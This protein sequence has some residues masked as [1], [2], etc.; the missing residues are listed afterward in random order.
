[1]QIRY[2]VSFPYT[3]NKLSRLIDD[4]ATGDTV[5]M[6]TPNGDKF[7]LEYKT[8]TRIGKTFTLSDV[9]YSGH[10]QDGDV[11]DSYDQSQKYSDFWRHLRST[12]TSY[13]V[14]SKAE[15][16][17]MVTSGKYNVS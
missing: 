7:E 11:Y 14:Y 16:I 17:E 9:H 10:D 3:E 8:A 4:M 1:M 2:R 15:F 5:V 13:A 12:E 6:Q